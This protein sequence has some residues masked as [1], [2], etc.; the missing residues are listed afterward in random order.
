MAS[1]WQGGGS[2]KGHHVVPDSGLAPWVLELGECRAGGRHCVEEP[3]FKHNYGVCGRQQ[4]DESIQAGAKNQEMRVF[5]EWIGLSKYENGL[6]CSC[7][8]ID[9]L[10]R[11]QG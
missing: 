9:M 11:E 6:S 5:N 8:L 4:R 3:A 7:P 1:V 2:L 10:R